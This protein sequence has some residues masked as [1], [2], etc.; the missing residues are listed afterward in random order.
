[1]QASSIRG[2]ATEPLHFPEPLAR[3]RKP[4][5]PVGLPPLPIAALAAAVQSVC[6]PPAFLP[7]AGG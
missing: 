6:L 2:M 4:Q 3:F 7:P 1:M 5:Y